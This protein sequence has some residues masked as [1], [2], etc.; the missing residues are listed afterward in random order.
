MNCHE[1]IITEIIGIYNIYPEKERL[2]C[3]HG[4][5]FGIFNNL[6][7]KLDLIF[8]VFYPTFGWTMLYYL[9]ICYGLMN[10][11]I[12]MLNKSNKKGLSHY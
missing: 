6:E 7:N 8:Q 1:D 2:L 5:K 11:V 9:L 4:D 3:I 12:R 10:L